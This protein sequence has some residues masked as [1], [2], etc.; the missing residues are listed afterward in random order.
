MTAQDDPPKEQGTYFTFEAGRFVPGE[1]SRGPWAPNTINGRMMGGLAMHV[2]EQE[3]AE[4]EF[5]LARLT[6]DLFRAIPY[7]PL[8]VSTDLVRK[9]GRIRVAGGPQPPRGGNVA[10]G[11]PPV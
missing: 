4:P 10:R 9:G 6:V 7:T 11:A 8:T 5:Q 3:Q 2:L 1:L